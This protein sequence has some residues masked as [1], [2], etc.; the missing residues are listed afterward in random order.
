MHFVENEPNRPHKL[1][2][3]LEYHM[4]VR[5]FGNF[6]SVTIIKRITLALKIVLLW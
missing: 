3:F 4:P 5:E 6:S 2:T 1:A